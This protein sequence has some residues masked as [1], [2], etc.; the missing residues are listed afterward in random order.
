V[1]SDPVPSDPDG[2]SWSRP[3]VRENSRN[4]TPVTENSTKRAAFSTRCCFQ[5][6]RNRYRRQLPVAEPGRDRDFDML[7]HRSRV[8]PIKAGAI[9]KLNHR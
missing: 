4:C 6:G 5:Y 7:N 9:D 8:Q 3:R 1:L 2:S